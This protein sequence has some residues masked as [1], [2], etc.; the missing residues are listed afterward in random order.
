LRSKIIWNALKA[1]EQF[2][3]PR[4]AT[5]LRAQLKGSEH[6]LQC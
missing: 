6:E 5:A 4:V 3:A 1:A 2:Y